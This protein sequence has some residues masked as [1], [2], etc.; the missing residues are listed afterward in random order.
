M[1]RPNAEGHYIIKDSQMIEVGSPS[2]LLRMY[3]Q[4]IEIFSEREKLCNYLPHWFTLRQ[5]WRLKF[6]GGWHE[7]G[8]IAYSTIQQTIALQPKGGKPDAWVSNRKVWC[9]ETIDEWIKV[10]DE[11]L[12][13]YLQIHN[14]SLTVPSRIAIKLGER[15]RDAARATRL[16]NRRRRG[17]GRDA[18]SD[19]R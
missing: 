18:A 2:P 19:G 16:I 14:P 8:A 15:D 11:T 13:D 1:L 17:R 4:L 7:W 5:A 10:T 12:A 6:G 9:R 3:Y